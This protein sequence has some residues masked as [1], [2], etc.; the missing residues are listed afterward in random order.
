[1]VKSHYISK[2]VLRF[3]GAI[4]GTSLIT[5][6]RDGFAQPLTEVEKIRTTAC[7]VFFLGNRSA[8]CEDGSLKRTCW[9]SLKYSFPVTRLS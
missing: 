3:S 5:R 8:T 2:A 1:M 9:M 6:G 4:M 7:L